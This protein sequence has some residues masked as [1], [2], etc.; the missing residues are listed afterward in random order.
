MKFVYVDES[1]GQD[2][3]DVFVMAGVLI[4]A[5]RLRKYTAKFDE[6]I[7]AF[8]EKH[9]GAPQEIKTKPF[10]NGTG[11]WSKVDAAERKAFLINVCD[12]V[13]EC[14]RVFATGISFRR[15]AEAL[16]AGHGHTFGKS[17]W[18]GSAMFVA[19]LVQK[20]MLGE[21]GNKGL[22]VLICDDNKQEMENLADALYE[23]DPWFDPLYQRTRKKKGATAWVE[24][25]NDERFDQIVNCAFAIKS[26]HSSLIQVADVVSYVYR[27]HLEL[28]S[29]K[30][31]WE[32]E[33][34]YF[35]DLVDKL[36]SKRE[37]LGRNPGGPCIDFYETA[38]HPEWE[39]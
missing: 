18:L 17:Y 2:Q 16:N 23:A 33:R 8:L 29:D 22:T 35:S 5:Y 21:N 24:I 6:M 28:K 36:D 19:A 34:K 26:Q 4:D 38:R 31:A 7:T 9:P 30:E 25:S 15:F 11:G 10:I 3:G 39:L 1:G 32:G 12:L 14:A 27:R 37:H 13:V 20:R